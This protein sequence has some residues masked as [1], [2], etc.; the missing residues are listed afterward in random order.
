M[1]EGT[2]PAVYFSSGGR[3]RCASSL[4]DVGGQIRLAGG[5]TMFR[6]RIDYKPPMSGTDID[7]LVHVLGA[8]ML[9][10][11]ATPGYLLFL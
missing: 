1:R 10:L 5:R 8:A 9:T 3:L 2:L 11:F 7:S 4:G 6:M